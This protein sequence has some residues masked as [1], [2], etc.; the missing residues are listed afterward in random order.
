MSIG[1]A[2][3]LVALLALLL[4]TACSP[5][6]PVNL[7]V[8]DDTYTLM[9]DQPYGENERQKLDVYM[10]LEGAAEAPVVVFFYGG[11][12]RSG[13]RADYAFVGEAL[14]SRGIITVVADY[15]VYP[16][17]TYPAFV[18]DSAAATAWVRRQQDSWQTK[19]QPM[20]VMGHSA[21]AYNAAML[22][23][24]ERWLSEHGMNAQE[25]AGWIGLSG[26]YEFLPIINPDV[27]PI[28]HHPDTPETSQP[29]YHAGP[30]SPPALLMAATP[31]KLVDPQ[32]NTGQLTEKLRSAGVDV[33]THYYESLHHVTII[34]VMADPLQWW[35]P[36]VD[37]VHD[38]V[39]RHSRASSEPD[40]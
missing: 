26:P 29:F 17:V 2:K 25:I 9:A 27:K 33:E 6:T 39:M 36:V 35:E 34:V 31:D 30:Q 4:A 11:S 7:L 37:Q 18:E 16:E 12:W 22:A 5:L 20:F 40:S 23:L 3:I 32:R 8:P 19:R 38:F 21:G 15:R 14:A 10:P 24:D 28:F 1:S 13:N